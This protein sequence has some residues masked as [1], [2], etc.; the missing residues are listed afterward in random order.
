M[1]LSFLNASKSFKMIHEDDSQSRSVVITI[2]ARIVCPSVRPVPTFQNLTKQNNSQ[3]TIV[4]ATGGGSVSLAEWIIDGTHVLFLFFW[5]ISIYFRSKSKFPT[6]LSC[7]WSTV[8]THTSQG[9]L[10]PRSVLFCMING[11][12]RIG[13]EISEKS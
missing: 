4:I 2:F 10:L 6:K 9:P 8:C 1:H 5:H 12:W 13:K 7:Y 3:T 11:L